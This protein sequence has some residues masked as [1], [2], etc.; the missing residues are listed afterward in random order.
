MEAD[1]AD[2][3]K[4]R[5]TE[6]CERP[7]CF[8]SSLKLIEPETRL[9]RL[10]SVFSFMTKV[11]HTMGAESNQTCPVLRVISLAN[12]EAEV[13]IAL[14][15]LMVRPAEDRPEH[16][17]GAGITEAARADP[18][19]RLFSCESH[20]SRNREESAVAVSDASFLEG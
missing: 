18:T 14:P 8:A 15:V 11:S 12:P 9:G 5:E 13:Q 17:I 2:L 7:R 16:Q 6:V 19:A 20:E 10:H 3:F 1:A 4:T